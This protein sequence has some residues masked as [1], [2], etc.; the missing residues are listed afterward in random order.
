M[1]LTKDNYHSREN[2]AISNSKVVTYLKSKELYYKRY[3][4]GEAEFDITPSI[5]LGRIVDEVIEHGS[6]DYF[7]QNYYVQVKK[8]DNAELFAKLKSLDPDQILTK[9]LYSRIENICDRIFRSPFW[10]FYEENDAKFQVPI[11]TKRSKN[12]TEFE[13]CGLVDV[14]TV[15]GDTAYID[16]LKTTN[17]NS[18]K[19]P[20]AWA[21]HCS[22]YGYFR[23]MAIYRELVRI[24]YTQVKKIFCRHFVVST[25]KSD[26]FPIKLYTISDELLKG[27]YDGFLNTAYAITVEKDW[28]DDLPDW[29]DAI[30]VPDVLKIKE[31]EAIKDKKLKERK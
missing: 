21:Y 18:I 7:K 5:Q 30:E 6:L 31:W 25:A 10:K 8:R 28:E 24:K 17:A 4:T 20:M 15:I 13:I 19:T 23:Q 14:L 3:I 27:L 29:E 9:D 2:N 12:K 22:D 11:K 16:D 1:E 26:N